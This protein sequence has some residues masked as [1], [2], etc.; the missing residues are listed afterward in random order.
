MAGKDM[1][2]QQHAVTK[3]LIKE[4][5]PRLYILI[6]VQHAQETPI[7]VLA[8]S[9]KGKSTVKAGIQISRI[10]SAVVTHKLPLTRVTEET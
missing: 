6:R 3:L 4:S 1:S 8:V 2:F 9:C 10:G 7:L 5:I